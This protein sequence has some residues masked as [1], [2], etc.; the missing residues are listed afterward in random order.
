[1]I[2]AAI[3]G[4]VAGYLARALLPGKQ[5]MGFFATVLLGLVGALIGFF[6]FTE[7]LGIG[8][9]EIFDLGGLIGAVIG[10]MLVL[11]IYD[12]VVASRSAKSEPAAVGAGAGEIDSGR[13]PRAERERPP[14]RDRPER[15]RP[16]RDSPDR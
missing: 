2:G 3:L 13:E 6:F 11:F 10:A 7:V 4:I 12:R 8:D 15:D 1:V 9:T 5:E 14:G 16:R